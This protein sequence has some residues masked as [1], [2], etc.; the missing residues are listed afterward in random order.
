[1][2]FPKLQV[3]LLRRGFMLKLRVLFDA[4]MFCHIDHRDEPVCRLKAVTFCLKEMQ[5]KYLTESLVV[6]F[7]RLF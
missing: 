2:D 3:S 1:M 5:S 6:S 4:F 7:Y